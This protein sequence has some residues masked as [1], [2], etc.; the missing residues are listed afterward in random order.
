MAVSIFFE[1][2][3]GFYPLIAIIF[4]MMVTFLGHRVRT[5][6][7]SGVGFFFGLF[8]VLYIFS[9]HTAFDSQIVPALVGVLGACVGAGF[10][11]LLGYIAHGVIFGY[12]TSV[13]LIVVGRHNMSALCKHAAQGHVTQ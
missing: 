1:L 5:I 10:M 7:A 2:L 4:G 11:M 3:A 12:V 8:T 9:R 6:F 13:L